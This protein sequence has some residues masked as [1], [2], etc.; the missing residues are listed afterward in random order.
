MKKIRKYN[1]GEMLQRSVGWVSIVQQFLLFKTA[2]TENMIRSKQEGTQ[3]HKF[4]A[5]NSGTET[6][7][8]KKYSLIFI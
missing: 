8:W 4:Y 3:E 7:I 2:I 1:M 5:T 6:Y